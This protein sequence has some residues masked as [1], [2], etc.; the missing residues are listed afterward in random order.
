MSNAETKTNDVPCG[1]LYDRYNNM[2]QLT[3][4]ISLNI[5]LGF[6]ISL[7]CALRNKDFSM[8]R[9][10]TDLNEPKSRMNDS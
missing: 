9:P 3:T 5:V 7:L 4:Q 10:K 2:R 8:Q 1:V 6:N